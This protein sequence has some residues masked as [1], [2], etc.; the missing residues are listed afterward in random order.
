MRR[1]LVIAVLGVAIAVVAPAPRAIG[2]PCE[3]L[4][5]SGARYVGGN[6]RVREIDVGGERVL[7]LVPPSYDTSSRRY[8]VVYLL[9]GGAHTADATYLINT[10]LLSFT[11][12]PSTREAIVVMPDGIA[13][14]GID[15][16]DGSFRDETFVIDTLVPA[17]DQRFRTYRGRS[18]RA[19]AGW[20]AGGFG[21]LHLAAK[22]PDMFVAAAGLDAVADIDM[23]DAYYTALWTVVSAARPVCEKGEP[24]SFG[25]LGDPISDRVWWENANPGAL[26]VNYGEVSLDVHVGDGS[27]CDA[28][29]LNDYT[30]WFGTQSLFVYPTNQRFHDALDRAGVDHSYRPQCGIHSY[31]HLERQL[32]EW[33]GS[34]A[35]G[36]PAPASFDYRRVDRSFSVWDWTFS[37]DANRAAEF[38]DV[39]DASHD[40]VTLTGSG[41]VSV[42]TARLFGANQKVRVSIEDPGG[43]RTQVVRARGKRLSFRVDLGPAHQQ[44]QFT[45]AQRALEAAGDYWTTRMVRFTSSR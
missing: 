15:W 4:S 23:S 6:E 37:A 14:L 19:I 18:H 9:P 31:R 36:S 16:R 32:H 21:A 22:R 35:F 2:D 10:D 1:S 17:I 3:D 30:A 13:S 7:V 42:R 41:E 20:S 8:P 28:Q 29:E 43:V 5:P 38:L 40:G 34:V 26:A 25:M 11:A 39:R 24:G 12:L 27:P 33:W 44:Q 45:P